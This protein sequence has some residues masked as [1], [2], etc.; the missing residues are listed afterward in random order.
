M[1]FEKLLV[2]VDGSDHATRALEAAAD[3]ATHYGSEVVLI[4]VVHEPTGTVPRGLEEFERLEH[5][6][7]SERDLLESAGQ[8]IVQ[9]AEAQIR[10][11]GVTN[12]ASLVESGKPA[13]AIVAHIKRDLQPTDGVVMGRRGL[14]DLGGLLL[15]S[16][17]HRV[18]HDAA[19]AVITV[20]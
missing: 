1:T 14:G 9:K 20:Q 8:R 19:C 2:A 18:A 5:V 6:H 16:V 13:P 12:V 3:L 11:L 10:Q 15:G 7:V 17:S 4:H